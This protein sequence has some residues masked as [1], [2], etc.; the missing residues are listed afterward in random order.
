MT[1]KR[2]NDRTFEKVT[3]SDPTDVFHRVRIRC[4]EE[5]CDETFI[6]ARRGPINPIA[7]AKWFRDKGWSVGSHQRDDLCVEHGKGGNVGKSKTIGKVMAPANGG[8][9]IQTKHE[10]INLGT[11]TQMDF[12]DIQ[13]ASGKIGSSNEPVLAEAPVNMTMSRADKRIIYNKLD[14]VYADELTGYR[15]NWN[16][17]RVAL[18]LGVPRDWVSTIREDTFGPEINKEKLKEELDAVVT[19]MGDKLREYHAS[20]QVIQ[21]MIA[22]YD[23]LTDTL[24]THLATFETLVADMIGIVAVYESA[25]KELRGE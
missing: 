15:G 9:N 21:S 20:V 24:D 8:A 12:E 18:D 11:E 7:A 1:E 2:G 25:M 10:N 19:V 17:E 3:A 23:K 13:I 4:S 5:G 6:Y 22:D 14:E 16:D